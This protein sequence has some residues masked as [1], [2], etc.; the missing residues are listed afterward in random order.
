F[1][2]TCSGRSPWTIFS[3]RGLRGGF[4]TLP[5]PIREPRG[6]PVRSAEMRALRS[7]RWC[8]QRRAVG[9]AF[10]ASLASFEQPSILQSMLVLSSMGAVLEERDGGRPTAAGEADA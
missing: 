6:L 10:G 7:A 3:T 8:A 1:A 9:P 2:V 5:P 4:D